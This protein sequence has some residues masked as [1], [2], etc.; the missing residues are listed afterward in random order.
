M[1]AAGVMTETVQQG[2][3]VKRE[4]FIQCKN[5]Y[6]YDLN[7][8]GKFH[9]T[10]R[11]WIM[12]RVDQIYLQ[13]QFH[14]RPSMRANSVKMRTMYQDCTNLSTIKL[15]IYETLSNMTFAA[16]LSVVLTLFS[17]EKNG[18]RAQR[19]SYLKGL[20]Q[21]YL[22]PLVTDIAR[23]FDHPDIQSSIFITVFHLWWKF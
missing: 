17:K 16:P 8:S 22:I 23:I 10:Y 13:Q 11:G 5:S 15:L 19:R 20:L 4:Y 7:Q 14:W 21:A 2:L 12:N 18:K 3:S 1:I 6:R 9:R